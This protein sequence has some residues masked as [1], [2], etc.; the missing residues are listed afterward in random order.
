MAKRTDSNQAEIIRALNKVGAVVQSLHTVG[1]GCPDLLVSFRGCNYLLEVK[2][3]TGKRRPSQIDWHAKWA[4]QVATVSSVEQALV[5][6][7]A[8]R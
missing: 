2:T 3:P 7:G 4:G 5:V 1:S 6:I 8:M